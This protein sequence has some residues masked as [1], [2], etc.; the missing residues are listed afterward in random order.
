MKT[1]N[2]S[3]VRPPFEKFPELETENLHLREKLLTDIPA[4]I[5]IIVYDG[6]HAQSKEEAGKVLGR[7][8]RDYI[9]GQTISWGIVVKGKNK[10]IGTCGF[11]RGFDNAV[12]EIGYVLKESYRGKG[13]MV[14]ALKAVI[15]FGFNSLKLDTIIAFTGND[16]RRSIRL[17]EKLHFLEI[18]NEEKN[19][20]RK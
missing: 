11:Y 13:I 16:N 3:L 4:I 8:N 14:E 2:S 20:D 12:G 9:N 10:M 17:L 18:E 15:S 5:E 19:N 1:E 6:K 7:I